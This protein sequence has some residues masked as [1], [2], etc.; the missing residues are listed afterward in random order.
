[1]PAASDAIAIEVPVAGKSLAAGVL[2]TIWFTACA[3]V[4]GALSMTHVVA[5]PEPEQ[6][7]IGQLLDELH[8]LR[9]RPGAPLAVHVIAA[10]CSCTES[11]YRHLMAIGPAAGTDEIIL[12]VGADAGKEQ[13]ALEAGYRF[14]QID[15]AELTRMGLESAPVL[16]LFNGAGSINYLGGYYDHPSASNPLD[17]RIRQSL[18]TGEVPDPMPIYGCAVSRRLQEAFDPYG[19]VY[20]RR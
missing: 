20:D 9:T 3:A 18:A 4:L 12:F 2:L 16:A 17:Q 15:Q 6:S 7:A 1:M 19:L 13:Q 10:D 8:A 11:L 5:L 14:K